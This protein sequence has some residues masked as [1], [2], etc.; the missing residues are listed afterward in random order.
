M[1]LVWGPLVPRAPQLCVL[2]E[3]IRMP[4]DEETVAAFDCVKQTVASMGLPLM[5]QRRYNGILNAMVMLLEDGHPSKDAYMY[6]K[7][8]LLGL[9]RFDGRDEDAYCIEAACKTF[10]THVGSRML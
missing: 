10:E 1:S 6:L 4:Y 5:Q 8:A 3:E 7:S 2:Q 9:A